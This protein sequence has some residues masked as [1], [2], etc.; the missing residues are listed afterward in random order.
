MSTFRRGLEGAFID[1]LNEEYHKHGWWHRLVDDPEVFIAIR[2]NYVNAYYCGCSLAKLSWRA[3]DKSIVGQIHYKYLLRPSGPNEYVDV[4]DGKANLPGNMDT[5]FLR[6]LSDVDSLKKAVLP[7][8]GDEKEGVHDILKANANIIDV[9]VAFGK[10]EHDSGALRLDFAALRC[11]GRRPGAAQHTSGGAKLVFFEAK[12]FGNKALRAQHGSKPDVV[13]QMDT[14]SRKLKENCDAV[15]CGY[16][17]VCHGLL[18]LC[19]VAQR[20]EQHRCLLRHV[21]DGL[22]LEVDTE[23]VLVVL[24][25]DADQKDGKVWRPHRERLEK[26]LKGRISMKGD[27]KD[28][29]TGISR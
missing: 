9:E 15:K 25:F 4:V 17:R 8:S 29:K 20:Y 27:S 2:D 6:D 23:P 18:S 7:Y 12:H 19:G 21:A 24:G 1:A 5:W 28:L 11:A 14:Y 26:E 22:P 10:G 13:K 16:R 3:Q